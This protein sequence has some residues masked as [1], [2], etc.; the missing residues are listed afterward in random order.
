MRVRKLGWSEFI[1]RVFSTLER[2][3]TRVAFHHPFVVIVCLLS[4]SVY[5]FLRK[6]QPSL[7]CYSFLSACKMGI[8][9]FGD[10]LRQNRAQ[11]LPSRRTPHPTLLHPITI[12]TEPLHPSIQS[13]ISVHSILSKVTDGTLEVTSMGS[14]GPTLQAPLSLSSRKPIL[15]VC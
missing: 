10:Q 5:R 3:C 2:Y 6:Q 13:Q 7:P 9:Y 12:Q 15:G 14:F 1:Q 8:F 4:S 11:H